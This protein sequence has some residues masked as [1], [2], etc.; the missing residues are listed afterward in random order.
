MKSFN[1]L[2]LFFVL[3]S[4]NKEDHISDHAERRLR[5]IGIW[6][7]EAVI[8][9]VRADTIFRKSS[10]STEYTFFEDGVA[11]SPNPLTGPDS[12]FS[13]YYQSDPEYVLIHQLVSDNKYLVRECK[14]LENTTDNQKWVYKAKDV[15]GIVDF[16]R[17]TW[18]MTKRD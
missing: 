7:I 13:W 12:E 4:C 8:E 11:Q 6:D 15:T 17:N 18:T 10:Y 1:F 14:V 3:F 9:E 16:W 2:F 5:I